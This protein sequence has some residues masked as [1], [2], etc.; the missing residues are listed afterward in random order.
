MSC[1]K[2][3][4]KGVTRRKHFLGDCVS[5]STHFWSYT[6]KMMAYCPDCDISLAP[7]KAGRGWSRIVEVHAPV[8]V[9]GVER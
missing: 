5:C 1:Q 9:K 6:R 2:Q 4:S 3:P 8:G 7:T